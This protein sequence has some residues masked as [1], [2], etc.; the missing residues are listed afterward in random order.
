MCWLTWIAVGEKAAGTHEIP[1]ATPTVWLYR[2]QGA[3]K[4]SAYYLLLR[5]RTN[6]RITLALGVAI[7]PTGKGSSGEEEGKCSQSQHE[8]FHGYLL[9]E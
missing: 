8:S 9:G 5:R 7:G 1:A 6:L 2:G 3:A 4:P